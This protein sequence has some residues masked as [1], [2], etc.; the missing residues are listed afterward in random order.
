MSILE[1]KE[2]GILGGS[3]DPPHKGHLKISKIS[4]K[5]IGLK[6]I[7][8]VVTKKNPFKRKPFFSLEERIRKSKKLTSKNKKIQVVYLDDIVKSSCTV[9]II[10]YFK[11]IKKN[12]NLYFILGSDNLLNFHKW[13]N[14]KKIVKLSKLIVFSRKGYVKKS[15]ESIVVKHLKQKNII[16]INNK[17]INISSSD[18]KKN[19]LKI[20]NENN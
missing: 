9:D 14:W 5:K 3:F 18:I 20:K 19:Q 2:F 17:L 11:K 10:Q 1:K 13:T 15:R 4:I 16:Y 8:W 12:K 7:Y 6:K